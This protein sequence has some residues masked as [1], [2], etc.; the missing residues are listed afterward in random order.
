MPCAGCTGHVTNSRAMDE[1]RAPS[2]TAIT[3]AVATWQRLQAALANDP[4]LGNDE[5]QISRLLDSEPSALRPE[6]LVSRLVAAIAWADARR[7]EAG[8]FAQMLH[9]RGARYARRS[10]TMRATLQALLETFGRRSMAT[11][12]GTAS[13][14]RV[15]PKAVVTDASRL[16]AGYCVERVVREPDYDALLEDLR[17]GVLIPGAELSNEAQTIR[18]TRTR[19]TGDDDREAAA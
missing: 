1:P 11:A 7:A 6:Q 2:P 4:Q 12:W 16:P 9:A 3:Q 19:A 15:P 13:L 5:A 17:Q 18:I 8:S 14:A 10:A